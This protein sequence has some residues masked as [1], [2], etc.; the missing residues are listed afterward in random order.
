MSVQP[1][2][3]GKEVTTYINGERVACIALIPSVM[4]EITGLS[5]QIIG[6][7]LSSVLV[8]G[9]NGEATRV[10]NISGCSVRCFV[11]CKDRFYRGR[12]GSS[13]DFRP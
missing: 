7:K 13:E 12:A 5:Q 8:R 6:R 1:V 9:R 4:E 2:Q 11:I 10:V 3:I